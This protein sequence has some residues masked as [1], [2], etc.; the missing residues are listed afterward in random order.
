MLFALIL[1]IVFRFWILAFRNILS[2]RFFCYLPPFFSC[3]MSC[4]MH[5]VN[6]LYASSFLFSFVLL[7]FP[8]P[9][10]VRPADTL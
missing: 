2:A 5:L 9:Y 3:L 1:R 8:S 7:S 10:K 4:L 6:V